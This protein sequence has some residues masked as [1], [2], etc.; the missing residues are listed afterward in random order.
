MTTIY[1]AALT[2]ITVLLM[3]SVSNV[4]SASADYGFGW[5]TYKDSACKKVSDP[6]NIVF[7]GKDAAGADHVVDSYLNYGTSGSQAGGNQWAKA[8]GGCRLQDSQRSRGKRKKHHIRLWRGD[9]YAAGGD[10]YYV[11]GDA[12]VDVKRIKCG[13]DISKYVIGQPGGT[14]YAPGD[15]VPPRIDGNL[16]GFDLGAK[17]VIYTFL[18]LTQV[19]LDRW[20]GPARTWYSYQCHKQFKTRWNGFRYI[21][22]IEGTW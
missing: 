13:P 4:S 5:F 1:R 8:R 20:Q 7:K 10:Y 6:V 14:V 15:Y 19:T 18:G 16:S 21:I 3:T 12:H 9:A 11:G 22:N 17:E 2:A